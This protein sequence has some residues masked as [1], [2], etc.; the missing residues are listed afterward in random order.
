[1]GGGLSSDA[2]PWRSKERAKLVVA[3]QDGLGRH[4]SATIEPFRSHPLRASL[5]KAK[6]NT[7]PESHPGQ[8]RR[9]HPLKCNRQLN[10][11]RIPIRNGYR[12][13][14]Q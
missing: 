2:R 5:V 14:E 6:T 3:F 10:S 13:S 4:R 1:V 9:P 11:R 12:S 8:V 7:W